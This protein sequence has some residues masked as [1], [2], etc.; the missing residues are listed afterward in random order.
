[1]TIIDQP[2]GFQDKV[3]GTRAEG[4]ATIYD[5]TT[6]QPITSL[7]PRYS[8]DYSHNRACFDPTDELVLCD[9]V[10]W[11]YRA[12][13]EIHKLDKLNQTLSG[14]FHPGGLEIISNTEV[15]DI[16][17]FHL[18]RTVPQLD[19]CM[20]S[21]SV[22]GSDPQDPHVFGPPGSGFGSFPFLK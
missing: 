12:A 16:R 15:W 20:V 21:T 5:V 8:N 10:L 4:V 7:R 13:R 18:L 19:Q 11:D 17:T 14:V 1:M 22:G 2:R 9:G 3:I 6:G